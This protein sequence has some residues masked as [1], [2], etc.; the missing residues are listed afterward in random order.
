METKKIRNP[1][2]QLWKVFKYEILNSYRVLL[3]VYAVL[4]AVSLIAGIVVFKDSSFDFYENDSGNLIR[5]ILIMLA[6]VLFIASFVVSI[7]RKTLP[8]GNVG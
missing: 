1:F 7:I 4:L 3:P 2:P 6:V 5:G 8:E